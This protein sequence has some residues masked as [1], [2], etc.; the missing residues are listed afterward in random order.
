MERR[1]NQTCC[2]ADANSAYACNAA[3]VDDFFDTLSSIMVQRLDLQQ[4]PPNFF[5]FDETGFQT[6]TENQKIFCRRGTKPP[7]KLLRH[8]QRRCIQFRCVAL[9][10]ASFYCCM[11]CT[12]ANTGTAHGASLRK[13]L[14]IQCI[15][16]HLPGK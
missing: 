13:D 14:L 2:A 15:T 10:L 8:Q 5:N 3:F 12:R 7:K 11:L 6:D 1:A 9:L 16:V 4:K